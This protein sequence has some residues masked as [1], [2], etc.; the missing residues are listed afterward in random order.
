MDRR[1]PAA[2]VEVQVRSTHETAG[3]GEDR[4]RR[5]FLT[6]LKVRPGFP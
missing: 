6:F 2:H 5:T 1:Q 4:D 3:D